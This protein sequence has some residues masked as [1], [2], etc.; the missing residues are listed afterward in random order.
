MGIMTI[1]FYKSLENRYKVLPPK[2]ENATYKSILNFSDDLGKPFQR[3]CR[4]KEGYS[5][6]LVGQLIKKYN[7]NDNGIIL[8]PFL[9]S[10]STI[11]AANIA[12]L[13]GCGFEVNP[14]S[15]HLSEC[16][17]RHYT[18]EDIDTLKEC[19]I[20][21]LEN[22]K[23]S[24]IS[25]TMPSLSIA[26][27]VFDKAVEG[28]Y[29]RIYECIRTL[30]VPEHIRS[31]LCLGWIS[32]I[33]SFSNYRK[34]GNGLKMKKY[35]N[36]LPVTIDRVHDEL[37]ELYTDMIADISEY[38][39][40]NNAHVIN[41][42]CLKMGEYLKDESVSGIIFSPPYANCFDYTE[43]YKLEL[44][45]GRYVNDYE[46][47]KKL[48]KQSLRSHLNGNLK[49]PVLKTS[50][51]LDTLLEELRTKELWDRRIVNMLQLYFSDMFSVLESCHKVL[52]RDGFCSIIIGNSSYSNVVIPTDL[53]F[54]EYAERLGFEVDE[55]IVDRYIITSAQQYESTKE[56]KNYLRES[57]VCLKKR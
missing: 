38:T 50:P 16:K 37:L 13:D 57:I 30:D 15:Y 53:L 55:I 34:A 42:T 40:Y 33:E 47:L 20:T 6:D 56:Y 28:Y 5:L 25:Y 46:D 3:W 27:K 22:A 44:W 35:K 7:K 45:F 19:S 11:I 41:D 21:I 48:R 23:D 4:Y 54:A 52:E 39:P 26:G 36:P 2:A 29:M 51:Y 8:D 12:G 49:T 1:D 9:G 18:T 14:F 43:I 31:F 24:S 17:T 10:G 32:K